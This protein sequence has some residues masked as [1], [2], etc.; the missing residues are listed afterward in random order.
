VHDPGVGRAAEHSDSNLARVLGSFRNGRL[1]C[2]LDGHEGM[3]QKAGETPC[4]PCVTAMIRP[5]ASGSRWIVTMGAIVAAAALIW[6]AVEN[7]RTGRSPQ[8]IPTAPRSA[9]PET[10]AGPAGSRR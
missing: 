9:P 2:E 5:A 8:E 7:S 3:P 10:P 6:S 1:V 4:N